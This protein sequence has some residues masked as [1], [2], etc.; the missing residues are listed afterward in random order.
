MKEKEK[1]FFV[2][3]E[4]SQNHLMMKTSGIK[5]KKTNGTENA[6]CSFLNMLFMLSV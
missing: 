1:M 4:N 3:A 6:K 2:T 5:E